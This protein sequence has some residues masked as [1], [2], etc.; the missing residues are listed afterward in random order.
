MMK[1]KYESA[2]EQLNSNFND[3][4]NQIVELAQDNYEPAMEFVA[5][6]YYRGDYVKMDEPLRDTAIPVTALSEDKVS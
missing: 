6:A 1:I 3:A 5:L 4:W 2:V